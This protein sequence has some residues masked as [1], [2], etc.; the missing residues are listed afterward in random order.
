MLRIAAALAFAAA[1]WA[2]T[3]CPPTP[4]YSTCDLVFDVPSA[5]GD[6]PLDLHAEFRSPKHATALVN[7]FWDGG[8]KWVIRFTPTEAG[9]YT[10]RLSGEAAS[11]N[12]KEGQFTATPNDK[13]GWVRG[14]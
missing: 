11:L 5:N 7:A 2:Q 10:F 14:A 3:V 1:A 13:T 12:G 4:R 8:T 9:S 6:R